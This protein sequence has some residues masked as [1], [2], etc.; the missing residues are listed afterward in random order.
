MDLKEADRVFLCQYAPCLGKVI[1]K[2]ITVYSLIPYS[3]EGNAEVYNE[4]FLKEA[5]KLR[6]SSLA[7]SGKPDWECRHF[8]HR[9]AVSRALRFHLLEMEMKSLDKNWNFP[10]YSAYDDTAYDAHLK[11]IDEHRI[12]V[13]NL[14]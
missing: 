5:L 6:S 12:K 2:S 9:K 4:C 10:V 11:E 13:S 8:L 14:S 3:Q 1:Q 7:L